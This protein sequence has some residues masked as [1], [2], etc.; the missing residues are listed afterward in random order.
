MGG[1]TLVSVELEVGSD[2]FSVGGEADEPLLPELVAAMTARLGMPEG[3]YD[4][5][6]LM[7]PT[8]APLLAWRRPDPGFRLRAD[9]RGV[10]EGE[11]LLAEWEVVFGVLARKRYEQGRPDGAIW[12]DLNVAN[13]PR[14]SLHDSRQGFREV[15]E[16]ISDRLPG[17]PGGW[18]AEVERLQLGNE[19][20][21]WRRACPD[22]IP[23]LYADDE[24]VWR[25]DTPGQR[26][27]VEWYEIGRV[28]GSKKEGAPGHV[29]IDLEWEGVNHLF[30]E[31]DMAG[32]GEAVEAMTTR[33]P[34]MP[35]AW[36][37]KIERLRPGYALWR[38]DWIIANE[39]LGPDGML[40]T[41]WRRIES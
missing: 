35:A 4:R 39:R 11:K 2:S 21:V 28:L 29:V 34:H 22:G 18:F 14:E 6:K 8:R 9:D 12:I 30:L 5:A 15:V 33:L 19:V 20:T 41:T 23:R 10:W 1:E 32:F 7:K 36:L 26:F 38:R 37:E 31:S 40:V 17:M 16:A 13:A 3:W 25:E 24:G 27:G